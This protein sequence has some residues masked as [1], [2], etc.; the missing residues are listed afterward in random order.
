MTYV[1]KIFKKE[2]Q[3]LIATVLVQDLFLQL[4]VSILKRLFDYFQNN[5]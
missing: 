2:V 3:K 5:H 1:L 4:N